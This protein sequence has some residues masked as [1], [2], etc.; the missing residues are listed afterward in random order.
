[1]PEESWPSARPIRKRSWYTSVPG[2]IWICGTAAWESLPQWGQVLCPPRSSKQYMHRLSY[3]IDHT[4]YKNGEWGIGNG[5]L[6]FAAAPGAGGFS[7]LDPLLD[8]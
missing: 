4:S 8:A 7:C 5:E 2:S 1:M 3:A 6:W